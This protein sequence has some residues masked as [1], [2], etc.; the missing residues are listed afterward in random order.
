MYMYQDQFN[1]KYFEDFTNTLS[2][3]PATMTDLMYGETKK[4]TVW[5]NGV[6]E[7]L[8]DHYSQA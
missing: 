2:I 6:S 5:F 3:D 8:Y 7:Q 4:F 1:A